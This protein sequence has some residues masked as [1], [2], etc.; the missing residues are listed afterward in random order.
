MGT[1][2][3]VYIENDI[4]SMKKMYSRYKMQIMI[5]KVFEVI[6]TSSTIVVIIGLMYTIRPYYY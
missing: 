4:E 3:K 1:S 5:K 2:V 6:Q